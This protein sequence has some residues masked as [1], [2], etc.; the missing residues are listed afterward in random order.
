[1]VAADRR[2]LGDFQQHGRS[3]LTQTGT[4]ILLT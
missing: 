2:T 3:R 1:V 4:V